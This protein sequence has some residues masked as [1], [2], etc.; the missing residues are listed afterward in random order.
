MGVGT[1]FVLPAIHAYAAVSVVDAALPEG[2]MSGPAALIEW[3]AKTLLTALTT[4]FT[5]ALAISGI[6]AGSA[7][8]LVGSAA[9]TVVGVLPV[10][11]SILSDAT[12]AYLAG[13][14]LLRGSVG[15]FGLAVVLA[16]C[17]GPALRLGAHYILF[18]AAACVAKPFADGRLAALIGRIASAFG[19]ALGLLGSAGAMLFISVSIG[20]GVL[21]G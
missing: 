15:V 4:V 12:D 9:K 5:L 21:S 1:G 17:A 11:G 8:K 16:V 7:D 14:Q 2:A 19:M 13:A 3:C 18:K 6:V 20:M 10:V